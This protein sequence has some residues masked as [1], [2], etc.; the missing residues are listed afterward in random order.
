[1]CVYNST[2]S[3]LLP[4]GN[5][6]SFLLRPSSFIFRNAKLQKLFTISKFL[7]LITRKNLLTKQDNSVKKH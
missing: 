3:I 4:E 7:P 1:M 6:S 2:S 5:T